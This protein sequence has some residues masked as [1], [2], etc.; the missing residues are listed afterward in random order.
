VT[1]QR[2][3]PDV[4]ASRVGDRLVL[5]HR[6]TRKA[7]VLNPTGSWLWEQLAAGRTTD[8]LADALVERWPALGHDR[9]RA[10]AAA[11]LDELGR[12]DMLSAAG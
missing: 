8:Q 3:S 1:L 9:A 10:D 5:Y 12:H 11:F 4:D 7:L 2:S 6:A